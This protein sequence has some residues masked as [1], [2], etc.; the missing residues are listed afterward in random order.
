MYRLTYS[1]GLTYKLVLINTLK[2]QLRDNISR[3]ALRLKIPN[4]CFWCLR[5]NFKKMWED[6]LIHYCS[7]IRGLF[8]AV[9]LLHTRAYSAA[10]VETSVNK[11]LLRATLY[12][13]R[14]SYDY[15]SCLNFSL[16]SC[17]NY[18]TPRSIVCILL[19]VFRRIIIRTFFRTISIAKPEIIVDNLFF[20][21]FITLNESPSSLKWITK[22]D[23]AAIPPTLTEFAQLAGI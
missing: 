23:I 21:H 12:I 8:F 4:R 13:M 15:D 10:S 1:V 9:R 20:R 18:N 16:M 6:K 17:Q 14:E 22:F 7:A 2:N 5:Q 11:A 19:A 3:E